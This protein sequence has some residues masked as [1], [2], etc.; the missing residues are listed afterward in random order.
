MKPILDITVVTATI[1][2]RA[3]LLTR[4]VRSVA[5]QTMQPRAH[6]IVW[7]H[8]REGAPPTRHRGL[9][10]VTTPWVAFLDDDD[11]LMPHHLQRLSEHAVETGAD[12]VYSWFEVVGGRDPFPPTHFS[13]PFDPANPIETT[14]TTLIRTDLAQA[15]GF[16]AMNRG[17]ANTGE[18]YGMLLG[19]LKVGANIS[20][21]VERTWY[22][23]HDSH[24]TS[25]RPDRW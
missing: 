12:Y 25:G 5:Q 4:A 13:E 9:M 15:I 11:E 6:F 7:D 24:N 19:C 16:H 8:D 3:A 10:Q 23:H 17:E 2:P 21:L 22:W 18:D 1:P 14:I 20:H